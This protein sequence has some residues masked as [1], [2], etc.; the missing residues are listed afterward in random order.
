MGKFIKQCAII[1]AILAFSVTVCRAQFT[2]TATTIT[3][4]E[5]GTAGV[6]LI[7][8]DNESFTICVP[9]GYRPQSHPE[10]R[11]INFASESG[12]SAIAVRFSTNYARVLPKKEILGG[13][14]VSNHSGATLAAILNAGTGVGPAVAYDL[15]QPAAKDLMLRI[16]EIYVPY[17]EGSVELTF[18]C[19]SADF[20]RQKIEFMQAVNSFRLLDKNAT[21]NP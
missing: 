6:L 21:L 9:R 4:A 18:S 1:F 8:V 20:D 14:V 16:R 3:M 13:Q 10:S 12:A 7:G 17:S 19:N 2:V 5:G 15:F 11:T